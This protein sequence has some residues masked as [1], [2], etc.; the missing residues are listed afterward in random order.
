MQT[1]Q[2]KSEG[3]LQLERG[4]ASLADRIKAGEFNDP[5]AAGREFSRLLGDAIPK[6]TASER[7][8]IQR[9]QLR[10][11]ELGAAILAEHGRPV[12]GNDPD[13]PN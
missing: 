1:M 11:H 6:M 5:L 9:A 7:D 4:M 12:P 10:A 8:A 2:K 13:K 3:Q